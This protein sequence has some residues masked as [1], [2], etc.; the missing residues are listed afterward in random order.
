[1]VT[2]VSQLS[3]KEVPGNYRVVSFPLICG[4]VMDHLFQSLE[5]DDDDDEG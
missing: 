1:M 2:P 5:G 4:A 3:K